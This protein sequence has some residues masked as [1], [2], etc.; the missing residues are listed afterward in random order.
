MSP[1]KHKMTYSIQT[2]CFTYK[3]TPYKS[4]DR[5]VINTQL[6]KTGKRTFGVCFSVSQ[7][8]PGL[9]INLYPYCDHFIDELNI[10][11]CQSI[12]KASKGLSLVKTCERPTYPDLRDLA[13]PQALCQMQV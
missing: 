4:T 5:S 6:N 10:F 3:Q 8:N 9:Y 13:H 7:V 12:Y 2:D 1:Y 11:V